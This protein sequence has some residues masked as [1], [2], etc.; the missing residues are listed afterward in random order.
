MGEAERRALAGLARSGRRAQRTGDR[1][2]LIAIGLADDEP[3]PSDSDGQVQ[4]D[5]G[6]PNRPTGMHHS[7]EPSNDATADGMHAGT[8]DGKPNTDQPWIDDVVKNPP[9]EDDEEDE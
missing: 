4:E 9:D 7:E 6:G 1:G 3:N 8:K 2:L 5:E